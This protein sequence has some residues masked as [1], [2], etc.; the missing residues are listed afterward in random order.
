MLSPS[1]CLCSILSPLLSSLLSYPL[2]S[3][4]LCFSECAHTHTHMYTRTCTHAPSRSL[5]VTHT[6]TRIHTCTRTHTRTHT[7]TH[8]AIDRPCDE[9]SRRGSFTH[10]HIPVGGAGEKSRPPYGGGLMCVTPFMCLRGMTHYKFD[11][12]VLFVS[13]S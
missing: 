1:P 6:H 3:L 5:Y 7:H 8:K 12:A 4:V 2:S 11:K 13:A 10:T 9:R